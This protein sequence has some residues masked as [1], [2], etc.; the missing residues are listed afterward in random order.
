V[1]AELRLAVSW[2]QPEIHPVDR[3]Q[4]AWLARR[5]I[6]A[7]GGLT[8]A[9]DVCRLRRSRLSQCQSPSEEPECIN[10][11]LPADAIA[12]LELYCGI[13]IYSRAMMEALPGHMDSQGLLTEACETTEAAADLQRMLRKALLDPNRLSARIREEI[14]QA[15]V[16][17]DR[18]LRQLAAEAER[19]GLTP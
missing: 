12:A 5:L 17:V 8:T 19:E 3:K 15:L 13:P 18:E 2:N 10:A 1:I 9:A 14:G 11:Y 4:H 16:A 7:C 6:D